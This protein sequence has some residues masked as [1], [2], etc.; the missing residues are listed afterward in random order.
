MASIEDIKLLMKS[1]KDDEKVERKNE[2]ETDKAEIK[3][4][5]IN[6]IAPLK[7]DIERIEQK[8]EALN[9]KVD[10][11]KQEM[12]EKY[13]GLAAH[14]KNM[15]EKIKD[16]DNKSAEQ[17]VE[18]E[19][20]MKDGINIENVGLKQPAQSIRSSPAT[21]QPEGSMESSSQPTFN[22]SDR[23]QGLGRSS[24][25]FQPSPEDLK[26]R[27]IAMKGRRTIGIGPI[28]EEWIQDVMEEQGI[29][30]HGEGVQA[31]VNEFL[32]Y[33]LSM[34]PEAIKEL[35]ITRIFHLPGE[36]QKEKVFIE[37]TKDYMPKI[38]FRYIA[39]LSKELN[40]FNY[41]PEEFMDRW[42][43]LNNLAFQLRH[44][45]PAFKT[46][47][48][49]G[50]EDLVLERKLKLRPKDAF[51]LV[52]VTDL[53][54]VNLNPPPLLPR[55]TTSP[56]PGR[57]DR[58]RNKRARSGSVEEQQ[59]QTKHSKK[60]EVK[61]G[62]GDKSQPTQ[63]LEEQNPM[64]QMDSKLQSAGEVAKE[65]KNSSEEDQVTSKTA[66]DTTSV[67]KPDFQ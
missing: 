40:M 11:A 17:G 42:K 9:E 1:L 65:A 62:M 54:A 27:E 49:W 10:D 66:N 64:K 36:G 43:V 67:P 52:T 16:L 2:R 47:I 12:N 61:G 48:R 30:S 32:K 24:V 34:P 58:R 13:E 57:P 51:R 18:K 8:T 45:E 46:K 50:G 20:R 31:T 60:E 37:F 55:P 15:E 7:Q 35:T 59:Q 6:E 14:I 25:S 44:A 63:G 53:P 26:I 38:M 5:I 39:K 28:S 21:C 56:A 23:R 41:I 22:S 4:A 19:E 3:N 33:E 29:S